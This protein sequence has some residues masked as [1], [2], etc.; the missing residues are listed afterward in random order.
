MHVRSRCFLTYDIAYNMNAD[1]R[2]GLGKRG[3]EEPAQMRQL[4]PIFYLEVKGNTVSK[5][6]R[7]YPPKPY[8]AF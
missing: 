1:W 5:C 4:N 7:S 3:N 6:A 8:L 2:A